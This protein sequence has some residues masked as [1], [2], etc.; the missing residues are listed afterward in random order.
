[1]S[2]AL[3]DLKKLMEQLRIEPKK[4]LGQNFLISDSV[5][6]KIVDAATQKDPT[7]IYEIGPGL[8]ALTRGLKKS[9]A[10]LTLLELDAVFANHWR[11]EGLEVVEGDALQ[12]DWAQFQSDKRRHLVSN[13]PYQISSSLV[14]DRSLD[15]HQ[16]ERMVLMF[17]KEVAQR[18]RARC[19]DDAYGMLSVVAQTFWKIE[20]LL[21]AGPRDFLPPPKIASRVL[22]F[23]SIPSPVKEKV[24]YFKFVKG[25]FLHPRKLMSSNLQEALNLP[26][27]RTAQKLKEMG[28]TAT[29]R[30]EE[31]NLKQ[32]LTFF[33]WIS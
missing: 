11:Q 9:S 23:D 4:S 3:E 10:E 33:E 21:E 30:A 13:L 32:F 29:A 20:T 14:I 24:K 26:K 22:V 6:K 27:E 12:M 8:G 1:M 5:I 2:Q 28:L 7:K 31:L 19:G 16:F 17:Q 15:P 18:I 25:A